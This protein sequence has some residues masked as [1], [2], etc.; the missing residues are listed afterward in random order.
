M[1]TFRTDIATQNTPDDERQ[2]TD[3]TT[4]TSEPQSAVNKAKSEPRPS[5]SSMT[6]SEPEVTV[7]HY[8][9]PFEI[10]NPR[11]S[12]DNSRIVSFIE[13]PDQNSKVFGRSSHVPEAAPSTENHQAVPLKE[14]DETQDEDY[15]SYRSPT[16]HSIQGG[17]LTTYPSSPL[18]QPTSSI[19]VPSSLSPGSDA[20]ANAASRLFPKLP[21]P[22]P[23]MDPTNPYAALPRCTDLPKTP[24]HLT[25]PGPITN[26][27]S[28]QTLRSRSRSR[29]CSR[30]RGRGR[31]GN[32]GPWLRRQRSAITLT[33]VAA[34]Q[35]MAS[36]SNL[37]LK[38]NKK[39]SSSVGS[40]QSRHR[41]GLVVQDTSSSPSNQDTSTPPVPSLGEWLEQQRQSARNYRH[42]NNISSTTITAIP[43]FPLPL[44]R[45]NHHNNLHN[46][47][48]NNNNDYYYYYHQKDNTNNINNI[49]GRKPEEKPK[50]HTWL[51]GPGSREMKKRQRKAE[52]ERKREKM[53]KFRI[54]WVGL[55]TGNS[56]F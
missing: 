46:N 11:R 10:I 49:Y 7:S 42:E 22:S 36:K 26:K 51:P 43:Q 21:S 53:T 31:Q 33:T 19:H 39:R 16:S 47:N 54:F 15:F 3:S 40:T 37:N 30:G 34:A 55:F 17:H 28:Q 44:P 25:H 4:P 5:V 35:K 56:K 27:P 45:T 23:G 48:N 32:D 24:Q 52:Q 6:S 2:V 8:G 9:T 12:L 50:I 14:E 1:F 20:C 13:E 41:L 29:S 18:Q 38:F